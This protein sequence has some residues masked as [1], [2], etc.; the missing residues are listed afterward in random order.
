MIIKIVLLLFAKERQTHQKTEQTISEKPTDL[1][2]T[3]LNGK[4]HF[5]RKETSPTLVQILDK[6][7]LMSETRYDNEKGL[8]LKVLAEP[9]LG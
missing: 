4:D 2:Q 6:P 8:T 5:G 3:N 9:S 7:I 1:A